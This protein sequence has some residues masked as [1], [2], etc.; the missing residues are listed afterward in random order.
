MPVNPKSKP[1]KKAAAKKKPVKQAV[2]KSKIDWASVQVKGAIL[3]ER[4]LV[5]APAPR[6][7]LERWPN[8]SVY[9]YNKPGFCTGYARKCAERLFGIVYEKGHTW[10]FAPRN[11]SVLKLWKG[12]GKKAFVPKRSLAQMRTI[13]DRKIVKPGMVVAVYFPKSSS[14]AR[15]MAGGKKPYT[16]SMLYLGKHNKTHYF[17][18]NKNGPAVETLEGA[19]SSGRLKGGQIAEIIA[20]KIRKR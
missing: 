8:G 14:N 9:D 15:A 6:V 19:L 4:A 7:S 10:Y 12:S 17:L 18:Q 3:I 1:K 13:L 20:P 11:R 5:G 2:A 16:H